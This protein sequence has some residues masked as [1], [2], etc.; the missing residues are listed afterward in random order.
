MAA[1]YRF[2]K[3]GEANAEIARLEGELNTSKTDLA[4]ANARAAELEGIVGGNETELTKQLTE[5]DSQIS[6]LT[7]ERD[8]FKA[9]SEV[10][11]KAVTA[12][13]TEKAVDILA[14][15]G[16]PKPV[17]SVPTE[18]A[19]ETKEQKAELRGAERMA[20]AFKIAQ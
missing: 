20:A 17:A 18:K 10:T 9:K 19:G 5:K 4:K 15:T 13:A 11:E 2:Y 1:T 16:L 8:A 3:I 14:S 6:A 12:K 7:T